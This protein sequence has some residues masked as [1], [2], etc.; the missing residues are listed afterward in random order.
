MN[1]ET[2]T[3]KPFPS[4]RQAT[5]DLLSAA[6]RK[7]MIHGLVEVDVSGP[8]QRLRKVK[9]TTGESISFTAFIIHCCARVVDMNKHMHAYRDWRNR[10]ILFDEVD[11]AT[12]VERVVEG[13]KEVVPTI[14]RAANRKSLGE[15]SREIRRVQAER[16]E[17]AGVYR[18]MRWYLAIPFFI[19]RLFFPILNRVPR[20]MKK[21]SGTVM[22]TS[23]GMFGQGAGWGVPIAT[24]T[25]NVTVGGIVSRPCLVGGQLENREQLC[26]TIS[27][28]HDIIDGAPAARF[29]Q[30]FKEAIESAEL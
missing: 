3:V 17:K 15:I 1:N 4:I 11:V 23:V 8:R 7:H 30:R 24:H 18:T 19:R 2:Y 29:I 28:D 20:L 12:T 16:A 25:L 6:S 14:I 27:F 5:I 10:L 13:R 21:N 22:V 9:E 26:L